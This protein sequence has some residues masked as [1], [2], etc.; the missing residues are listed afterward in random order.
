[1]HYRNQKSVFVCQVK[2]I[3]RHGIRPRPGRCSKDT[4]RKSTNGKNFGAGIT[5]PDK[6][7]MGKRRT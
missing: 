1:M 4:L 6:F 2:T 3:S 5:G 7:A